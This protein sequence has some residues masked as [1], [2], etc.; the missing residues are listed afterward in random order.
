MTLNEKLQLLDKVQATIIEIKNILRPLIEELSLTALEIANV[1]EP[2][3]TPALDEKHSK[4]LARIT[5]TPPVRKERKPLSPEAK[6][7]LAEN[8]KKARAAKKGL[9]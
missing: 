2:L 3:R 7:K 8:L 1:A 5:S 9:K 4:G 6:L